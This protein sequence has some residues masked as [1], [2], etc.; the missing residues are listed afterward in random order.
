[1]SGVLKL[2]AATDLDAKEKVSAGFSAFLKKFFSKKKSTS[3]K[4]SIM[5]K[6]TPLYEQ[7]EL[8]FAQLVD[9][10]GWE[11]PIN[12]GSQIKEHKAVRES[13]GMFDVS[14]MG[15]L[16]IQGA[17]ATEFLRYALANDVAKLKESNRALYTCLLNE[18]GGIIDDLIVYKLADDF[19][20]IV[21]NASRREIDFAWF[22]KLAVDFDV[23]L[24]L[25][26]ELCIAAIQ[27]PDA[28]EKVIQ[29]LGEDWESIKTLKPFQSMTKGNIQVARTGYTGEDGVE[30]IAPADET[31]DMWQKLRFYDVQTCGL[32]ARDTLR[33]EAGLNLYG[34]DMDDSVTPYECGLDWTVS[35][36]DTER[37]FVGR[38]ALELHQESETM[39]V[40]LVMQERGVLRNHQKVFLDEGEGEITSGSFSPTLGYSIAFAR[41]PKTT[42]DHAFVERRDQ[43]I[44]VDI[45]KP[46][47]VRF[48][49][50]VYKLIKEI[51]K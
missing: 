22:E 17:Q 11:M 45:V 26:P 14:H 44:R 39:F 20:R 38:G 46:P 21:L 15:V 24:T 49:K 8:S 31:I 9:F 10:A 7:H 50:K 33:L 40:G 25:R 51:E 13:A 28:I 16:D 2:T 1:M 34:L 43:K 12:Y 48:G 23:V 27:G 18:E 29:A 4:E 32:G 3:V 6:Q 5:L 41:I 19:Y 36:K 42:A 47:F 30:V 35:L 37:H